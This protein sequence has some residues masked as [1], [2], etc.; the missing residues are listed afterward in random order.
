MTIHYLLILLLGAR[1]SQ[2]I[3]EMIGALLNCYCL[4]ES[5]LACFR[6]RGDN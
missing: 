5:A 1:K 6:N 4:L 2:N 3:I